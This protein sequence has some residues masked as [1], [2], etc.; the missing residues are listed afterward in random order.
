MK[1][2]FETQNQLTIKQFQQ[3]L[4]DGA[5]TIEQI[6]DQRYA[7][8]NEQFRILIEAKKIDVQYLYDSGFLVDCHT[9]QKLV[10]ERI[11]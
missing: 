7:C 10:I 6:A 5:Y 2:L 8:H 1:K 11:T 9:L 3:L 4:F